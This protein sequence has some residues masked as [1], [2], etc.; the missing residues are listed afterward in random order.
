M[1]NLKPTTCNICGGVVEY[2]E[3]S[4][5]YGKSY[6]SGFCYRCLNCD[7]YV[8]TYKDR[9][10]VAMGILADKEMRKW[11]MYCHD[12]FDKLWKTHYI[13]DENN[14]LKKVFPKMKRGQAYK[15][16]AEEMGIEQE[17]CH[18]GYF[19]IKELKRAYAIIKNNF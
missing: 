3:N 12:L 8:G 7:A 11:K 13:I 17:N 10:S 18:F 5:I 19:N 4:K 2:I 14:N 16:L 1:V 15:R 6:G 9:P